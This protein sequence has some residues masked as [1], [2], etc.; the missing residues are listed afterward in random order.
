[1]AVSCFTE[2]ERGFVESSITGTGSS[3]GGSKDNNIYLYYAYINTFSL[4]RTYITYLSHL[5]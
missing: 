1:M 2:I 3:S 4:S 5:S